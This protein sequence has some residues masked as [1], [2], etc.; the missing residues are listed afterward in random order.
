MSLTSRIQA[1]TAYANEVTGESDTTLADAV[2]TLAEGYGQGY[3][4]D[5]LAN[6][7]EPSGDIILTVDNAGTRTYI[8][9][10]C[11]NITSVKSLGNLGGLSSL[12]RGCTSLR[13]AY[14]NCVT[15][16]DHYFTSCTNLESAVFPNCSVFYTE[17][18]SPAV[19][20]KVVDIGG[21]T[22]DSSRGFCRQNIFKD[23]VLFDTLILRGSAVFPLSNINN[24][25]N[26]PFASNGTGG[27]LYV[28]QA[29]ISS[30]QSANNWST[31]LGYTNNQILPIEG[32]IYET[33]YAD[34][35]PIE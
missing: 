9:N 4:A 24:F 18:F 27:T 33:Q 10:G 2:A 30:Y 34:G 15:A 32:S 25:V 12:F 21:T 23:D 14:M 5:G 28:P 13:T 11:I 22:T 26:T 3:S 20:L 16:G 31:I 29:L 19:K 17:C 8:F 1:L 6:G 7:T 35:T